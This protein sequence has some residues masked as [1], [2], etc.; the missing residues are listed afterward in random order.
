M[1]QGINYQKEIREQPEALRR[2]LTEGR[3]EVE[4]LAADI[5]TAA[6]LYGLFA[7]RGSS[8]NAARYAQY[9]LGIHNNLTAGL[10]VPSF[11]SL[12]D[13]N[14]NMKGSLT[15]G[16]SQSGQSPDIVGV[17]QAATNQG[18]LTA[19][20]TNEPDS[21]LAKASKHTI[22]LR[23]GVESAVAATKTYTTELMAL[24]M[25]SA[26][27]EG[28]E[29]RWEELARVPDYVQQT[30]DTNAALSGAEAFKSMEHLVVIG[31]GYNYSTAF[32]TSL[33]IKETNYLVAEP[34]SVA[35]LLHGPVAMIG[36]GFPVL[37][38][39]PKGKTHADVPKILETVADR[40]A[41][42]ISIT[43]DEEIL[44]KSELGL[45]LPAMPEWV[46]PIAGVVAGQI[47]AGALAQA[48]GLDPDKPRGLS[49]VTLTH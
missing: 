29:E 37:L 18:A 13:S 35:D 30:I 32:E 12:Y 10:A 15:I 4:A 17:V 8:D 21:P 34:Y 39:A 49:K 46:S 19:A 20:I 1:S 3:A 38:V 23:A 40:K 16:V 24:A 45:K 41:R 14:P 2:L 31:R 11:F 26:A 7:A 9:V 27:M 44:G 33:K 36:E 6:P 43:D 28:K 48:N 25:I 22:Q 42:L 5:K 47:F